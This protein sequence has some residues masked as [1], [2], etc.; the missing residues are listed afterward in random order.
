[1]SQLMAHTADLSSYPKVPKTNKGFLYNTSGEQ[2]NSLG[3]RCK[4]IKEVLGDDL[5][6]SKYFLVLGDNACLHMHKPLNETWPYLLS[7]AIN[8]QY[9]NLA[10]SN[11][12]LE[13]VRYN[14]FNWLNQY[15]K[16]KMIFITCEWANTFLG[17]DYT[18]ENT[19]EADK[20][21]DSAGYWRARTRLFSKLID[22]IDIPVY[23]ILG[24]NDEPTIVSDE[25]TTLELDHSDDANV[26]QIVSEGFLEAQKVLSP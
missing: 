9:Y 4:E 19:I 14:L 11:A 8:H 6:F 20:R 1:V 17:A 22:K 3:H 10:V 7:K 15:S 2:L 18:H 25:I 23:L 13:G 26:A 5:Q 12:G 24:P 16:P 21:A